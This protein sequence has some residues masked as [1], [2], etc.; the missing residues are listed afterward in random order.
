[1][2]FESPIITFLSDMACCETINTN[3]V[4]R[5]PELEKYD[6]I[7]DAHLISF[8]CHIYIIVYIRHLPIGESISETITNDFN[9]FMH[10]FPTTKLIISY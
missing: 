8:I 2:N 10:L 4:T 7:F 3:L 9:W 5:K 1:M 6:V